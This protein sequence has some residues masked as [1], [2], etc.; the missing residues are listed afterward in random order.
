VFD[1]VC[2]EHQRFK[3]YRETFLAVEVAVS[4]VSAY[5][6]SASLCSV[7]GAVTFPKFFC[8]QLC[9]GG[10]SA[11]IQTFDADESAFLA[12]FFHLALA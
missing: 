4:Y 1:A 7:E 9:L 12:Q 8:K 11:A 3:D 2:G 10:F 6:S 5:F